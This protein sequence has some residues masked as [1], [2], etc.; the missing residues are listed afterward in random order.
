MGH[1]DQTI[2]GKPFPKP[3]VQTGYYRCKCSPRG[4]QFEDPWGRVNVTE[5]IS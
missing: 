1:A 2:Q 4:L 3:I 5:G